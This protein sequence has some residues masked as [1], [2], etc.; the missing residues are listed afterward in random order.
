LQLCKVLC[1]LLPYTMRGHELGS[2]VS[3]IDVM[4]MPPLTNQ[5]ILLVFGVLSD[6]KYRIPLKN[7]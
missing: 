3:G 2:S 7:F 5:Q 4:T 6:F 1:P